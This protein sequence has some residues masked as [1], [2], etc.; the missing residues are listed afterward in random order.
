MPRLKKIRLLETVRLLIGGCRDDYGNVFP[1][2]G[3]AGQGRVN[4]IKGVVSVRSSSFH[5]VSGV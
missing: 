4:Q 3:R 2:S 1:M 5:S